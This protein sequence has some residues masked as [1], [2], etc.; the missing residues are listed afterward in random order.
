[1][2]LP[3]LLA[4]VAVIGAKATVSVGTL[5]ASV[6]VS[7]LAGGSIVGISGLALWY[8]KLDSKT[9]TSLEH[10]KALDEQHQ[11]TQTR[12]RT[13]SEGIQKIDAELTS[14][15]D[16]IDEVIDIISLEQ[17]QL[18]SEKIAETSNYLQSTVT[19]T[20]KTGEELNKSLLGL[21]EIGAQIKE[22]GIKSTR[23]ISMLNQ[24]LD[25]KEEKL[26]QATKEIAALNKTATEQTSTLEELQNVI[27]KLTDENLQK[28]V[29][30][31]IL[32]N[33]CNELQATCKR[34]DNYLSFFASKIEQSEQPNTSTI[35]NAL[36]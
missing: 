13:A 14:L 29:K 33:D 24:L 5:I 30:I 3:L 4:P 28:T 19:L 11:I 27:K 22:A 2:P 7:G 15:S 32:E 18:L 9:L 26:T 31:E 10:M 35:S 36:K 34:M 20:Q 12:I 8:L 1:M 6:V 16:E 23:R 25:E 21:K 17:L